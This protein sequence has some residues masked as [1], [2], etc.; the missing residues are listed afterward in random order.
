MGRRDV[1]G[2][3]RLQLVPDLVGQA[4]DDLDAGRLDVGSALRLVAEIAWQRGYEECQ[5]A[6]EP[7]GE[8][9]E[10]GRSG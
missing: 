2:Q 4:L 8:L 9:W 6:E 5:A 10:L 3:R 7:G 1:A